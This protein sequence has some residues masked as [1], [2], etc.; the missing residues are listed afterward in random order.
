MEPPIQLRHWLYRGRGVPKKL[1][2]FY[3]AENSELV[4]GKISD[5]K[6]SVGAAYTG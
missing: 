6:R 4:Y 2:E 5:T 3:D 1:R